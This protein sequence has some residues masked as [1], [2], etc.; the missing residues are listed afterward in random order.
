LVQAFQR[1]PLLVSTDS[2]LAGYLSWLSKTMTKALSHA[3]C[4]VS[5]E[6]RMYLTAPST[7]TSS[8]NA[9]IAS[10]KDDHSAVKTTTVVS[11][12]E[13]HPSLKLVHGRPNIRRVLHDEIAACTNEGSISVDGQ[14]PFDDSQMDELTIAPGSC[15]TSGFDGSRATCPLL[16]CR[17]TS[18]C[19]KRTPVR[20]SSC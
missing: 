10:E 3:K 8:S 14:H 4:S 7:K 2:I 16:R 13:Y 6:L 12:T 17:C 9:S 20:H 1:L 11:P 18:S 5:I 15:W 19:V